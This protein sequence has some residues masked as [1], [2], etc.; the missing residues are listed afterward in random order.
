MSGASLYSSG[1]GIGADQLGQRRFAVADDLREKAQCQ[2]DDLAGRGARLPGVKNACFAGLR[3]VLLQNDGLLRRESRNVARQC[4]FVRQQAHAKAAQA[5]IRFGNQ[6]KG[7]T[8]LGQ[9]G[10]DLGHRLSYGGRDR[11][12]QRCRGAC[13]RTHAVEILELGFANQPAG[14]D[15]WV[16]HRGQGGAAVTQG[17]P[18][19]LKHQRNADQP[20]G[21]ALKRT[22]VHA[23]GRRL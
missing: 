14:R 13:N 22:A 11:A 19:P 16:G 20:L 17:Q 3:Q 7:Q 9:Q 1:A 23:G 21:H 5:Q 10:A 15:G 6:G 8:G 2:T 12:V 4:G 18:Q